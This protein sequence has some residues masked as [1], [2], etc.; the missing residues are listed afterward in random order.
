MVTPD[1]MILVGFITLLVVSSVVAIQVQALLLI[2]D[3][4][5]RFPFRHL[6]KVS[7]GLI[8]VILVHVISI[9]IFG[10]VIYT[11]TH[12]ESGRFGHLQGAE[13]QS[14]HDFIYF[15]FTTYTTVGYGDYVPIGPIRL[16]S[17]IEALVG[18][19]LIACSASYIFIIMQDY[20]RTHTRRIR[21]EVR[22]RAGRN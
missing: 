15:S 1:G 6:F 19:V 3:H 22:D 4:L 8:G 17:Q 2:S 12:V 9:V 7:F 14:L 10:A 11:L 18:L 20:W 5:P 13:P 16:L 21:A